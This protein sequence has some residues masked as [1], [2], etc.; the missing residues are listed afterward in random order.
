MR[1]VVRGT[2]S[3]TQ[4]AFAHR[5]SVGRSKSAKNVAES[6]TTLT[7]ATECAPGYVSAPLGIRTRN[8]RIKRA[9]TRLPRATHVAHSCLFSLRPSHRSPYF[10]GLAG[11]CSAL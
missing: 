10:A 5:L 7:R 4:S 2:Y 1:P 8:L 6:D 11:S 9:V 3:A